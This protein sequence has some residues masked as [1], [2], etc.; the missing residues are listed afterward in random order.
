[1]AETLTGLA[2]PVPPTLLTISNW[3]DVVVQIHQD[4]RVEVNEKYSMDEA[5]KKFWEAVS[6]TAIH[7]CPNCG[8]TIP[9]MGG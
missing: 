2:H 1:M 8:A 5:A 7:T 9:L 4:G 6:K 3:G